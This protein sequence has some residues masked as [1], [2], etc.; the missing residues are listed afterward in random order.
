MHR[1]AASPGSPH[2]GIL[3]RHEGSIVKS[4]EQLVEGLG[5]GGAPLQTTTSFA[6]VSLLGETARK[7]NV[8]LGALFR[9]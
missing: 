3:M 2:C 1:R 6:Q 7:P 4:P 9:T 8:L 5:L